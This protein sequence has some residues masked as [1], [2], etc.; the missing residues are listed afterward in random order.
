MLHFCKNSIKFLTKIWMK[1]S[2]NFFVLL[3]LGGWEQILERG[4]RIPENVGFWIFQ[5]LEERSSRED[6]T[7]LE[8]PVKD[9]DDGRC[10]PDNTS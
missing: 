9:E 3:I 2:N 8:N 7:E 4:Y 5:Y 10:S 1:N 6:G